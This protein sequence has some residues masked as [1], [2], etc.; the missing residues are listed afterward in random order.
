MALV[1]TALL[2]AAAIGN[3]G[4]VAN[5]TITA[6]NAA[7]IRVGLSGTLTNGARQ[8][9]NQKKIRV[10]YYISAYNSLTLATVAHMAK[11][12]EIVPD[13]FSSGIAAFGTPDWVVA[14]GGFLYTWTDAPTL[15]AQAAISMSSVESPV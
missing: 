12:F 2:T 14:N 4:A 6:L 8:G 7:T 3:P 11:Y 10:Y 15:D 5:F 1:T 9:N 13:Q